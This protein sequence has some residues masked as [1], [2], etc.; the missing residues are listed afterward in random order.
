MSHPHIEVTVSR[1]T[2]A[3][4]ISHIKKKVHPAQLCVVMKA[5]AY[6]HGLQA[7]ATTALEAGADYLGICTNPEAQII[8]DL[9]LDVKIMRLRMGFPE[10]FTDSLTHLEVEEQVGT[11]EAANYLSGEGLRT[12]KP[13]PVHLNIDTGMGR[14]GFFC[15]QIEEIKQ[16]CGLPGIKI[17]GIMTHFA[18]ADGKNLDFTRKQ[19][20]D[21]YHVREALADY[22]PPDVLTH[23]HNSAATMRITE[24]CNSLVRVGAVCHTSKKKNSS[25]NLSAQFKIRF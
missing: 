11:S 13:I 25:I 21:F 4:N 16:V 1:Q 2:F 24:K 20:E 12:D 8:R 17:V 6:G 14:S 19:Q 18:T 23:T 15:E 3:D 10:E 5:N 7:L 9:G 22:L